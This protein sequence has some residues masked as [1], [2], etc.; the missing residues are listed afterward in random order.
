[1]IMTDVTTKIEKLEEEINAKLEE[2]RILAAEHEEDT[3]IYMGGT[4]YWVLLKEDRD[5][6]DLGWLEDEHGVVVG[7]WVSSSNMC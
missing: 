1:M 3:S 4:R 2:L 7:D 5:E 6:E